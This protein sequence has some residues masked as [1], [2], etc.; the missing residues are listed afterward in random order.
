MELKPNEKLKVEEILKDLEHYRP[1]RRGWRWRRPVKGGQKLGPFRYEETSEN[2]KRS[3]PLP[4]AQYFQD[5][6][7]QPVA[8]ITTRDRFGTL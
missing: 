7:P 6:D 8:T 1:R 2:L 4:G 5:I 3:V